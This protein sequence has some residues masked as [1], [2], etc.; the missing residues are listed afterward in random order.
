MSCVHNGTHAGFGS[1]ETTLFCCREPGPESH[2]NKNQPDV[3]CVVGTNV[4]D[5]GESWSVPAFREAGLERGPIDRRAI[6]A[7]SILVPQATNAGRP[8]RTPWWTER[9][10]GGVHRVSHYRAAGGGLVFTSLVLRASCLALKTLFQAFRVA[11]LRPGSDSRM[12]RL[13]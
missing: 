6:V 2:A 9:E 13:C 5:F 10:V 12:Y 3:G 1:R 8:N 11:N 4:T 7:S